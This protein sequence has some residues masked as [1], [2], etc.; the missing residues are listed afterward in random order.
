MPKQHTAPTLYGI[1][2]VGPKGQIVIPVDARKQLGVESGDKIVVIGAPQKPHFIGICSEDTFQ[3]VLHKMG[4]DIEKLRK[5][6]RVTKSE[7]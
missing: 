7:K 3:E 5:S 6:V 2:T 4:E 1:A